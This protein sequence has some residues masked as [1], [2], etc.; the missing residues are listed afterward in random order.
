VKKERTGKG[1]APRR[2]R[3]D[4][5]TLGEFVVA[6]LKRLDVEKQ[7]VA[8]RHGISPQNLSAM[9][10]S[11]D[12]RLSTIRKLAAILGTTAAKL[13]GDVDRIAHRRGAIKRMRP[14]ST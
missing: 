8:A 12:P 6:R 11:H 2:H 4:L 9:L 5:S 14:S 3:R 7:A 1:Q 10:R 13:L